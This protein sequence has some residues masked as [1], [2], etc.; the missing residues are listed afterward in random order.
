MVQTVL[1]NLQWSFRVVALRLDSPWIPFHVV[2]HAQTIFWIVLLERCDSVDVRRPASPLMTAS[3]RLSIP[4]SFQIKTLLKSMVWFSKVWATVEQT[5]ILDHVK[6]PI[7][8]WDYSSVP[9]FILS[10]FLSIKL[11]LFDLFICR[12]PLLTPIPFLLFTTLHL[13]SKIIIMENRFV[14]QDKKMS[15]LRKNITL[16]L[17]SGSFCVNKE[18]LIYTEME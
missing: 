17:G 6:N 12:M 13:R 9:R 3:P 15:L 1:T 5:R 14:L 8:P 7:K 10:E 18:S 2:S 16:N 11:D 4:F